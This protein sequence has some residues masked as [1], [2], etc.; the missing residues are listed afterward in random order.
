MKKNEKKGKDEEEEENGEEKS[1]SVPTR[2]SNPGPIRWEKDK[3]G[4]L[5][6]P[7]PQSPWEVIKVAYLC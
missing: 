5:L 7:R 1:V 3:R 6:T 2:N 4:E